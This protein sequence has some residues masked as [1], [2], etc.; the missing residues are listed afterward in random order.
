MELMIWAREAAK[1][2]AIFGCLY[3]VWVSLRIVA[4]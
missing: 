3:I 4:G 2:F 1:G